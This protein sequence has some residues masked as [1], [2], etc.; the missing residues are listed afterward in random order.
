VKRSTFVLVAVLLVAGCGGPGAARASGVVARAGALP[1]S[2]PAASGSPS[3]AVTSPP[4]TAPSQTFTVTTRELR[5]SRGSD[6]PLRTVVTYP[7]GAGRF[8]LVLFSHGL[9]GTPEGYQRVINRIASAG[10][11]VAAPA[12]PFTNGKAPS[13]N[14]GDIVNQPADASAVVT[15]VL[16]LDTT[17]GDV[18]FGHL[19]KAKVGAAGHSAGGYT[20]AG[21]LSGK[22]DARV[23]AGV[24]IAGGPLG[25]AFNGGT[26]K[27]LFVHGDKDPVVPYTTGRSCYD[28]VP[29]PKGF[30]TLL[31]AGHGEYLFS[32]TAGYEPTAKTIVDFLRWSLYGD[33]AALRR[34]PADGTVSGV[35]KLEAKFG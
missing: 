14:A 5:L 9:T 16:E 1:P 8:P 32:N 27:M 28:K 22:R 35:A 4:A 18:L 19:D 34:L 26:A 33:G 21:I 25:G 15:R 31:G 23:T 20:T 30:L 2:A 12:Y 24:V 13:F 17:P 11:V 3:T 6:R 7:K 10:F 29:W